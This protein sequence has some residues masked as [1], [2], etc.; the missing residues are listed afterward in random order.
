M[1]DKRIERKIWLIDYTVMMLLGS[2]MLGCVIFWVSFAK[3]SVQLPFLSFP[4]FLGEILL[5]LCLFLLLVKWE[6]KPPAIPVWYWMV[7]AYAGWVLGKAVEGYPA[8][9]AYSFRN[10]AL[11][12]YPFFVLIGYSSFRRDVFSSPVIQWLFLAG[13]LVL[14]V[15]T[16]FNGYYQYLYFALGLAIVLRWPLWWQKLLGAVGLLMMFPCKSFF[17]DSKNIVVGHVVAFVFLLF[18]FYVWIS[19]RL[20]KIGSWVLLLC[21]TAVLICGLVF[22]SGQN[23]IKILRK[24]AVIVD[25]LKEYD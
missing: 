19:P 24:P 22:F 13:L 12:Y 11:F 3:L 4:I 5:V 15:T 7:L 2:F 21:L 10:A 20:G 1:A 18:V 14:K 8:S 6:I 16:G 25:L 17:Q 23:K 9:G